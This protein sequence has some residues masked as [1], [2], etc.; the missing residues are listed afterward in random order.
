MSDWYSKIYLSF[1]ESDWHS[2]GKADG[3]ADGPDSTRKATATIVQDKSLHYK[4][5]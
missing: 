1:F 3:K 2:I 5:K 4:Q